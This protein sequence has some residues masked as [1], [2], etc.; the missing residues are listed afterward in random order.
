MWPESELHAQGMGG[1]HP[2]TQPPYNSPMGPLAGRPVFM[3]PRFCRGG[4]GWAGDSCLS[5]ALKYRLP[6]IT[7]FKD[8]S[9]VLRLAC[10]TKNLPLGTA[11]PV[12]CIV[13]VVFFVNLFPDVLFFF[14]ILFYF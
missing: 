9:C 8:F 1:Q 3:F 6:W 5:Q 10:V 7:L 11:F 12:P 4:R 2:Q 13:C 14:L